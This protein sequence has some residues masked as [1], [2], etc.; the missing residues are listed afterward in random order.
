MRHIA[1][2]IEKI[3]FDVEFPIYWSD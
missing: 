2:R 3:L 1:S